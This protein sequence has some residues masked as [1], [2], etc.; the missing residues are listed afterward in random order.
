MVMHKS[1]PPTI[2]IVGGGLAG[3][4]AAILL[5]RAGRDVTIIERESHPHHK[6]C[7]EFL[8]REA[9]L[10]LASLGVDVAALGAVPIRT[11]RLAGRESALPFTAMSLT[12]R[13]LDQHLLHTAELAGA[14]VLRGCR[15]DTLTHEGNTWFA[16][17][18]STTLRADTL[19]LATGKHDLRA[20]PRPSGRQ[21]NLVAFKMYYHLA[22]DQAAALNATVELILYPG[23]Y[24]GLQPVEDAAA[25]LCCLIHRFELQRLGG[26]DALLAAMETASPL[27]RQR[28]QG[29]Q[30]LLERPLAISPIPYGYVR[31]TTDS[32][33]G[34]WTLGD[35]AA[36]IPSFTGDGMSIALHSGCLAATMYLQGKTPA[37]FQQQ[38]H[39][40]VAQQVSL[41]TS[42]SRGL[43]WPPSRTVITA[44]VK[45]WPGLLDIVARRTRLKESALL[46]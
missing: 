1:P 19:F 7:G 8:S 38:L 18:S 20:H 36:V 21:P 12:R 4:A 10:Y 34:L 13:K 3:S 26:W 42:I 9:I 11:V 46:F 17:L 30:P 31:N 40:E 28:L 43:I 29:A 45:L 24:A 15:V 25:N 5:S 27:L 32:T 35:Q 16:T 22:P 33:P 41:A 37:Q 39:N 6:V 14:K 44:A 2:V 23:G